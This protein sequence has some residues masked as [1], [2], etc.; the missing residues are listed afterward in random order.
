[1]HATTMRGRAFVAPVE[2]V[3]LDLGGDNPVLVMT[4]G[5]GREARLGL[6][7]RSLAPLIEAL[8]TSMPDK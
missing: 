3:R 8:G 4:T 6:E 7:R 5:P 2:D 1:M